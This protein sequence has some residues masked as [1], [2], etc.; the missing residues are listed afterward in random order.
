MVTNKIESR[1]S[2]LLEEGDSVL[3]LI[4]AEISKTN[5]CDEV[6]KEAAESL[7]NYIDA[8]GSLLNKS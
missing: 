2:D 6:K 7:T 3:E 1:I 5:V 8:L 4:D